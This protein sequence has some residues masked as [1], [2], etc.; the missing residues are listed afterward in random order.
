M[1]RRLL[2]IVLGLGAVAALLAGARGVVNGPAIAGA[3]SIEIGADSQYR[4]LS[5]LLVGL[6]AAYVILIPTIER[7]SQ[8]LFML[9][10][11][12]VVAG[13]VRAADMLIAG[14]D[15]AVSYFSLILTL[16]AAPAVYLWQLRVARRALMDASP[17]RG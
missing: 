5:G 6:A 11:I 14:P 15:G 2:Q 9:T 13:F 12:V 8:R 4:F 17:A 10:L 7:E 1:E 3:S 16:I